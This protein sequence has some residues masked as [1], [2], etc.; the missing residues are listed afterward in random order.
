[1][2][3]WFEISALI[4]SARMPRK[5]R[6]DFTGRIGERFPPLRLGRRARVGAGY[7]AQQAL[8][9]QPRQRIGGSRRTQAVAVRQ[10]RDGIE[11]G[12]V[13]RQVGEVRLVAELSAKDRMVE[14]V[15][16]ID[17]RVNDRHLLLQ[18]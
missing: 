1:M 6:P 13:S 7:A 3:G 10:R 17:D 14:N 12:V 18:A 16:I 5:W 2:P 11:G 4:A 9:R 15:R 8:R